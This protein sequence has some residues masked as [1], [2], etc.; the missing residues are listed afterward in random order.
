MAEAENT[1]AVFIDFENLAQ[2][3]KH[4]KE[5]FDITRVLE[6][7]V[8]KGKVI[9]SGLR[10]PSRYAKYKQELHEWPSSIRSPSA[11]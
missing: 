1:L 4:G 11:P 2:G 5:E 6:R 10:G 8:E 7:L 3:F 9:V